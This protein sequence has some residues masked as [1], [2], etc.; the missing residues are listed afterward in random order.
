[1]KNKGF[2]WIILILFPL[3]L[4]GCGKREIN[5]LAMVTAVGLDKGD[6]PGS[7]RI[8]AQIVR[9]ADARG[10]T[11][12]PSGGTGQPIY[13]ATADGESIFSAMRNL[14]RFTSRRIFWAQNF[15]I[16]IN[17][18]VAREGVS[19]ILDFFTRNHETRMNTWMV[20]T[21]NKASELVSTIT[22]LEVVPGEATDKLLRQNEIVSD[23]PRTNV[24]RF[25]ES[26]LS[27]STH[28]VLA[29]MQL[30][31]R[32]I[33]NK[34]PKEFGSIKQVE[35]TGTA[36]FNRDKMV[37]WLSPSNSRGLLFFIE[38]VSSADVVLPCPDASKKSNKRVSLELKNQ[39][40]QVNPMYK[41]GKPQFDVQ[42]ITYAD[43]VESE[44]SVPLEK[45]QKQLETALK[46]NLQKEIEGV[47]QKA[48]KKYKVDFLKLGE[49]FENRYPAEWRTIQNR[50]DQVFSRTDITV[51]VEA[52]VNNPVLLKLPTK[53]SKGSGK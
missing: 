38:K 41:N 28:P 19:D 2:L 34:K 11:G 37:G 16:V 7:I 31:K 48:Q 3:L 39:K 51:H 33:S 36:V 35:L 24:M 40:F 49:I 23:A 5:D 53:S 17:E 22:G 18:N 46:K 44:C 26:F 15:I 47:I 29:K 43:L 8:T 52:H 9:P 14:A 20:A 45:M 1:M 6:K 50:W 4:T 13:S 32:G 21:P 27:K 10:Q 12:A 42:L 25:Q 30:K